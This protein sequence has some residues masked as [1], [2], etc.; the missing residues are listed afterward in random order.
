MTIVVL[1][2]Q[3]TLSDH[4]VFGNEENATIKYKTLSWQ[5]CAV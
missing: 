1:N 3:L 4:D 2:R 5:L